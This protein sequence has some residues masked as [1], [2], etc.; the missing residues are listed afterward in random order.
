M[1]KWLGCWVHGW[2]VGGAEWVVW[3]GG[4]VGLWVGRLV[5]SLSV[6]A[7]W[8][9]LVGDGG[10]YWEK[11]EGWQGALAKLGCWGWVG[12]WTGVPR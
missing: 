5:W 6:W 11:G 10:G 7:G 3:V 9:G 1:G 8:V 4:K 2:L 12:A